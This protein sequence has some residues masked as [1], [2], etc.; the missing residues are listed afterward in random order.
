MYCHTRADALWC[1]E[2]W[3]DTQTYLAKLEK[4]DPA[5]PQLLGVRGLR[6]LIE[7]EINAANRATDEMPEPHEPPAPPRLTPAEQLNFVLVALR[8]SGLRYDNGA[9]VISDLRAY[10]SWQEYQR[11]KAAEIAKLDVE[12]KPPGDDS[13][14]PF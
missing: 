4:D 11:A 6:K 12:D 3:T 14:Q 13:D 2:H 1:V 5:K 9:I 7:T 8:N 10:R